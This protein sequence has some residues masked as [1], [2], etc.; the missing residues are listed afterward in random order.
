[1]NT[2]PGFL[3]IETV[4]LI[5]KYVNDEI[6]FAELCQQLLVVPGFII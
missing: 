1:M 5:N 4:V 3:S 2:F 6:I